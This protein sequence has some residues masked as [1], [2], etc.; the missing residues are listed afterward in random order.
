M[1]VAGEPVSS[2]P[3]ASAP[4]GRLTRTNNCRGELG[5]DPV[6]AD[7]VHP[8]ASPA[9][10]HTNLLLHFFNLLFLFDLDSPGTIGSAAAAAAAIASVTAGATATGG[11]AAGGSTSGNHTVTSSSFGA[12]ACAPAILVSPPASL[13]SSAA[14]ARGSAAAG[15]TASAPIMGPVVGSCACRASSSPARRSV[16]GF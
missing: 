12:A 7:D 3:C 15:A 5:F 2:K 13:S 9:V 1:I 14:A 4:P 11:C 8:A 16:V 10:P 6:A